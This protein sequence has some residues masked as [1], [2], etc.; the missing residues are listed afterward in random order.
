ML[1]SLHC[2]PRVQTPYL[3]LRGPTS[4][5]R[6]RKGRKGPKRSRRKRGKVDIAWPD[7]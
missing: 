3:D 7:L 1:G 6:E 4:Y 2:S 5:G